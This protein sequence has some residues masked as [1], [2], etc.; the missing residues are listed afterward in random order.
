MD[1]RQNRIKYILAIDQ[2]T[3]GSRAV[4]YDKNGAKVASSYREFRQIFPRP[5]WVEHDPHELWNS[6]N[7]AIQRV[8]NNKPARNHFDVG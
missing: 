3:T 8:R 1:Q 4:V 5:G 2:G 6:V 7:G